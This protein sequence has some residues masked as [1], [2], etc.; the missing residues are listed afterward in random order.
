MAFLQQPYHIPPDDL[1]FGA[2]DNGVNDDSLFF[3]IN[4]G[5]TVF[6]AIGPISCY[7]VCYVGVDTMETVFSPNLPTGGLENPCTGGARYSIQ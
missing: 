1:V 5:A 3:S 7:G 4:D 2:E 6:D